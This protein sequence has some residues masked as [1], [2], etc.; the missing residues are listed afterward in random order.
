MKSARRSKKRCILANVEAVPEQSDQQT[1]SLKLTSPVMFQCS[2]A[3]LKTMMRD[4]ESSPLLTQ[5]T[6]KE[7]EDVPYEASEESYQSDED[8]KG[9][10]RELSD[11]AIE[12]VNM[13]KEHRELIHLYRGLSKENMGLEHRMEQLER[14]NVRLKLSLR[15]YQFEHEKPTQ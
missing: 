6:F 14:E 11:T 12:D 5:S 8:G 7:I 10:E 3:E 15:Q 13:V 2:P 9:L 1:V 4:H